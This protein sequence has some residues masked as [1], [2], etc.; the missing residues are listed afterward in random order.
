MKTVKDLLVDIKDNT[1]LMVDL[2]YSS[3]FYDN[4]DIA[5]E[6]LELE[7][8]VGDLFKKIKKTSALA[9]RWYEEAKKIVS[10]LQVANAGQKISNASA[11]IALL[12][13]RG[14]KLS[15][16]IVNIILY[17]SEETVV[18]LEVSE[19]SEIVGKTL[20]ESKLHTRTGMRVIA[21]KRGFNWIFN[22]KK[23][24]KI[25]KGDILFAR[26]DPIAVPRFYEVVSGKKITN[27]QSPPEIEVEELDRAVDL[28]IEMKNLSELAV[29]LA[30]SSLIYK[31]EEVALEVLYLEELIDNKKFEV[32]KLLFESSKKLKNVESLIVLLEIAHCAEQIADAAVDIA[33]VLVDKM[34]IP[35][36]F[37]AA[38]RETD[39]VLVMIRVEDCSSIAGKTLGEAKVETST[40]MHIIAVKRNGE[41]ITRPTANTKILP[42]DVLIAKGTREGEKSLLELCCKLS[43]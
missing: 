26:G 14:Y 28:L 19:N 36:V 17:H 37:E 23:D 43:D 27:V 12:V 35:E 18:K 29:D 30:Y 20:K 41:W 15:S 5:E 21:I 2:A 22:P 1:E 31:N 7:E 8:R 11:D 3:I 39:E 9:A 38:M 4:E 32:L 13:L 24:V 10:I 34:E 6:V 25:L 40:G 42:K 16:E 33:R